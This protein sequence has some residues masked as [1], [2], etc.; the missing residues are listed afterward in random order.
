MLSWAGPEC[1]RRWSIISTMTAKADISCV[2]QE[3]LMEADG[4]ADA[5]MVKIGWVSG[6]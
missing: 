2:N 1:V 6:R 5:A 4:M 3:H